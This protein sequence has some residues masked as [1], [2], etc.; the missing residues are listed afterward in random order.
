MSLAILVRLEDPVTAPGAG[1]VEAVDAGAGD[2]EV[3]FGAADP[4][5]EAGAPADH[6]LERLDASVRS[7]GSA[8][9]PSAVHLH[10]QLVAPARQ[11]ALAHPLS[12]A[13]IYP[14]D[15]NHFAAARRPSVFVS[16]LLPSA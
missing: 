4:S 13:A 3:A 10:D 9:S 7:T 5:F 12:D 2:P 6:L 8:V 16:T 11:I 15:G 14:V 1:A